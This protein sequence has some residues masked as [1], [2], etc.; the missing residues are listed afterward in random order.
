MRRHPCPRD[1]S[2]R[3]RSSGFT[4]IELITVVVLIGI[5]GAAGTSMMVDAFSTSRSI[6]SSNISAVKARYAIERLAREIREVKYAS[7]IASPAT[8][9]TGVLT[10]RY[11]FS[12][13]ASF[14]NTL[15]SLPTVLTPLTFINSQGAQI[16]VTMSTVGAVNTLNLNGAAL[17]SGVTSLEMMFFQTD[18]TS[19]PT[20]GGTTRI[21]FVVI[22][23]TVPDA[24]GAPLVLRT[25]VALRNV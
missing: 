8:V 25:R 7:S 5:M 21:G 3:P 13:P 23:L 19:A 17:L 6:D 18:G 11:C 24:A 1:R 2:V 22:V 10:D 14:S 12:S 15:T 9:C 4:L 16:D 20:L